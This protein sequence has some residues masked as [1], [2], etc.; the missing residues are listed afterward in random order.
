[1]ERFVSGSPLHSDRQEV[2]A[3]LSQVLS[4]VFNAPVYAID[5]SNSA[6][7]GSAYRALHGNATQPSILRGLKKG[8]SHCLIG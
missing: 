2:T 1:M 6:C 3:L 5:L 8:L 7:L 4:D